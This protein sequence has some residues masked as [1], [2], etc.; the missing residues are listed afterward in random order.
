MVLLMQVQ[1]MVATNNKLWT[2][3]EDAEVENNKIYTMTQTE[4]Y[5]DSGGQLFGNIVMILII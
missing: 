1:D 3:H 4:G 5:Q 2:R